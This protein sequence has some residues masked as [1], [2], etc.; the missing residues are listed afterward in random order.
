MTGSGEHG[1]S[2]QRR[3]RTRSLSVALAAAATFTVVSQGSAATPAY[4]PVTDAGS[5]YNTTLSTGA[6]AAWQRGY[7]GKG[8][9]VA[10]IDT[11]VSPVPG[12]DGPG[13]VINGPDLS[14]ESQSD[15]LVYKDTYGHGTHMASIIAGRDAGAVAGRYAGDSTNFLGVAPDARIIN[16]KASDAEGAT[17]VTQ[18]IA[19]I[20]W[21]VQNRNSNGMNIRVINLSYGTDST[22]DWVIDPLAFAVDAA[23]RKGIFVVVA[24]GNEG[25]AGKHGPGLTNPASNPRVMAVSALDNNRTLDPKD[26]TIAGFSSSGTK[27]RKPDIAAPGRSVVGL[28][29]SGS[30]VALNHGATGAVGTRFFRGSGSSQSAAVVSG[31]AA[32][33][34]QQRPSLTP[35]QLKR[36]LLSSVYK[37]KGSPSE[38]QGKGA[39]DI[40]A[41][42][43]AKTA[44]DNFKLATA[45]GTGS[46]DASRGSMR[47]RRN[48]VALTGEKDIFGDPVSTSDLAKNAEAGRSWVAGSWNKRSWSGDGWT[49]NGWSKRSWSAGDWTGNGWTK[50]SWS[51]SGWS[52]SGWTGS[53]WGD[54]DPYGTTGLSDN[55]WS[56]TNWN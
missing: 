37:I 15:N 40:N 52:G 10:V 55:A 54:T 11:G 12:L 27:E 20:N 1:R 23:W 33:L 8:I 3:G 24:G 5:L 17:D 48:G 29:V 13:K 41:A 39:L 4:S 32:I 7:T 44:S 22:Q 38:A 53:G 30:Y 28:A 19:A 35:G 49:N 43:D 46:I 26:D 36:V 42:L 2:R 31:A 45:T 56:S 47:P 18:I 6:Q 21:V 16:M 51:D 9:D 34:L 14:Y 50:R 25:F